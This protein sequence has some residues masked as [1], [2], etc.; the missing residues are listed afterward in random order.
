MKIFEIVNDW[1]NPK[2]AKSPEEEWDQVQKERAGLRH[3]HELLLKDFELLQTKLET[4]G[5]GQWG[6]WWDSEKGKI[7]IRRR[8]AN[9]EFPI[10]SPQAD[11]LIWFYKM[12]PDNINEL[13]N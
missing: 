4:F 2:Q 13:K 10:R 5:D 1:E 3:E 8:I 9:D 11:T 12:T 6:N 7:E